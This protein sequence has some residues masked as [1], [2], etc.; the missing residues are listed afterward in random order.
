MTRRLP[1]PRILRTIG[2]TVI[3]LVAALNLTNTLPGVV[4]GWRSFYNFAWPTAL[5]I[6]AL[7]FLLTTRVESTPFFTKVL[8]MGFCLAGVQFVM[9]F[10]STF[11]V[12]LIGSFV[13]TETLTWQVPIWATL[14]AFARG[15]YPLEPQES[16]WPEA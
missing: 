16:P 5:A 13:I 9:G 2:W 8:W 14:L 1:S 3:G 11:V 12:L 7:P 4:E 10:F 15:M 6:G